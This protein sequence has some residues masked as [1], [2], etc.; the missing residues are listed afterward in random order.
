M[1]MRIKTIDST[2]EGFKILKGVR[3]FLNVRK[4]GGN[5]NHHKVLEDLSV[6]DVL[7]FKLLEVSGEGSFT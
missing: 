6:L 2:D 1:G 7:S 3:G 4:R 5:R